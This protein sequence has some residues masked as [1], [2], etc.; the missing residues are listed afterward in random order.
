MTIVMMMTIAMMITIVKVM[1]MTTVIVKVMMKV[2]LMTT[3]RVLAVC[4]SVSVGVRWSGGE[5]G[6][7][8]WGLR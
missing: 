1:M 3:M 6:L 2:M 5:R 7:G 8:V 4:V